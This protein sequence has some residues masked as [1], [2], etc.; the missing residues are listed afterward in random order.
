MVARRADSTER[1]RRRRNT[2]GRTRKPLLR[3]EFRGN[4]PSDTGP[5]RKRMNER[6]CRNDIVYI[7]MYV[8]IMYD[9]KRFVSIV[10]KSIRVLKN[11]IRS[12]EVRRVINAAYRNSDEFE[13]NRKRRFRGP[14][15]RASTC[16][17]DAR[18][19][20]VVHICV[21]VFSRNACF[22]TIDLCYDLRYLFHNT[23]FRLRQFN[24][25]LFIDGI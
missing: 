1:N 20:I 7:C 12:R 2:L 15:L 13:T 18:L 11:R 16:A 19:N 8:Y 17:A 24:T 25:D 6:S 5:P 4:R 23:F 3:T 9:E 21:D 14:V 10:T 22:E